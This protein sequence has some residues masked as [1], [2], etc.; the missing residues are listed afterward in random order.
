VQE[1]PYCSLFV[2]VSAFGESTCLC[3]VFF[4]VSFHSWMPCTTEAEEKSLPHVQSIRIGMQT[5]ANTGYL[6]KQSHKG[7]CSGL[8][9]IHMLGVG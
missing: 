4:L 9:Q 5:K 7:S 1:C 8:V 6:S 2:F 3:A